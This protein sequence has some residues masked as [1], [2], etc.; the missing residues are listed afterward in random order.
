MSDSE[1]IGGIFTQENPVAGPGKG[2]NVSAKGS[3]VPAKIGISPD[4]IPFFVNAF[5]MAE[6]EGRKKKKKKKK[7]KR[8]RKCDDGKVLGEF[9]F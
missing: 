9:H 1:Y 6:N 2:S 4:G 5:G 8:K 7:K 3:N